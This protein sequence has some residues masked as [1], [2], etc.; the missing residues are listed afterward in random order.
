VFSQLSGSGGISPVEM[1]KDTA[2][3][4]TIILSSSC[5][6]DSNVN[7]TLITPPGAPGVSDLDDLNTVHNSPTDSVNGVIELS[8]N[9]VTE[10]TTRVAH[11]LLVGINGD[12]KRTV[13]EGLFHSSN[14]I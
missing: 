4:L 11:E 3:T 10:D 14:R 5:G 12:C 1:L 6:V 8:V 13:H 2:R 7:V 9:T